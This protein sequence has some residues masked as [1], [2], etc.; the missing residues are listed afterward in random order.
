MTSPNPAG[1]AALAPGF[2]PGAAGPKRIEIEKPDPRHWALWAESAVIVF[3]AWFLTRVLGLGLSFIGLD[4]VQVAVTLVAARSGFWPGFFAGFLGSV[5]LLM[6]A[7]LPPE[8]FVLLATGERLRAVA[9]LGPLALGIVIGWV[10]DAHRHRQRRLHMETT[11]VLEDL[12][13]LKTHHEVV[14]RAKE[15]LDRRIVGQV[16][17]IT[18]VADAAK[19]LESLAPEAI[20][21][22]TVKLAARY[23]EAEAVSAYAVDGF[24]LRLIT[25]EGELPGRPTVVKVDEG[26]LGAVAR[27]GEPLGVRSAAELASS[28]VLMAAPIKAATGQVRAVLAVEKLPFSHLVPS[29]MQL[30]ELLAEWASRSWSNSETLK[31][32]QELQAVHPITGAMRVGLVLERYRQEFSVARRYKLPLSLVLVR[33]PKLLELP[34]DQRAE[35]AVPLVVA[36]RRLTRDVDLL[37][38]YRTDDAFLLV[39]PATPRGGVEILDGRIRAAVPDVVTVLAC[40]DGEVTNPEELLQ[41]LQVMAFELDD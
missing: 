41:L 16:Q 23:L 32:A 24:R 36:L 5:A 15:V 7:H 30:L 1:T 40:N 22:A 17:T 9:C 28:Q 3:L 13:E 10:G 29:S 34:A 4:L 38:H 19:A 14:A 8:H 20:L 39:L 18:A 33:Q 37:G 2:G 12:D 25:S 11:R 6:D 21:P 27:T 26:V 35:A 31:K